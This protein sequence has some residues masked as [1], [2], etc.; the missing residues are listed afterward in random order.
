MMNVSQ[1]IQ[2]ILKFGFNIVKGIAWSTVGILYGVGV[3]AVFAFIAL[4]GL[5]I[6]AVGIAL[7]FSTIGSFTAA[8]TITLTLCALGAAKIIGGGICFWLGAQVVSTGIGE[9]YTFYSKDMTDAF[10]NAENAFKAAVNREP[11][12]EAVQPTVVHRE[13]SNQA[14][15]SQSLEPLLPNQ[16]NDNT[17]PNV[18]PVHEAEMFTASY[19]K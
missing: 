16:D 12:A 3:L 18:Q 17:L 11:A 10:K 7:S 6:M 1:M 4:L 13:H 5:T 14:T 15:V 19:P 9:I 2:S 8:A